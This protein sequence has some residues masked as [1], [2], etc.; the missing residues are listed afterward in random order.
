MI[1]E[2]TVQRMYATERAKFARLFP[3]VQNVRLVFLD[4][5]FMENERPRDIAWYERGERAIF[6]ARKALRER[7]LNCIKGILR[8]ELGHAADTRLDAPG[9]E[10]RADR[11]AEVATGEPILYTEE[12]LQHATLGVPY[13]PDWLHQ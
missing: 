8:H 4:R 13:R 7:S 1:P 3:W 12:G 2:S 6:V 10:R 11:L 5:H 9:C